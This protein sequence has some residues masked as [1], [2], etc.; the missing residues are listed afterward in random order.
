MDLD[1]IKLL[2][3]SVF[4][5]KEAR[6]Y[7]A[8][9]ELGRGNVTEIAK[10]SGLKRPI[11]YV[12][13]EGLIKRG[14][15]SELP[16]RKINTYQATDPSVILVQ[17]KGITRNF[18]EMLPILRTLGNKSGKKP[19]IRYYDTEEGILRIWDG[20]MNN[21]KDAFF[22][23]SYQRIED[24]FSGKIAEW[25]KKAQKGII[26]S[27]FRHLIS[28]SPYEIELAKKFIQ[29]NQRVKIL[30][31]LKDSHMDFTIYDNKLAITSLEENPFIVV[32]ESDELVRSMRPLFELAWEKGKS[33]E[34]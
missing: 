19:K 26:E 32:I 17:L 22:I 15:V 34:K 25:I 23:S 13:L 31:E 7:L 18:S 6:V 14:Y 12:L 9:L 4:T 1:L 20:E 11:I 27:G 5:G 2:E 30:P 29:V 24:R 10:I 8:L 16:E 21:A 3:E 33:L 28:D